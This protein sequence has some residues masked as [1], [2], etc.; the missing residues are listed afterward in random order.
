MKNLANVSLKSRTNIIGFANIALGLF[1]IIGAPYLP[2][3]VSM[4]PDS[5]VLLIT[6]GLGMIY[7][8]EAIGNA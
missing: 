7:M 6:A 3:M 4:I 1:K 8:R 5:P 2:E